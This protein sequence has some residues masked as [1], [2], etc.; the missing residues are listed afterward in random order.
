MDPVSVSGPDLV[1]HLRN[2]LLA[3]LQERLALL[4]DVREVELLASNRC[5]A[6]TCIMLIFRFVGYLRLYNTI[7]C[8]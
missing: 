5:D 4:A 7:D 3:V 6:K 8:V 2:R 1:Q